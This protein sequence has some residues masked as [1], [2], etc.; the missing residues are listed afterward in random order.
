MTLGSPSNPGETCAR[1]LP[2]LEGVMGMFY[3]KAAVPD[4]Y[5]FAGVAQDNPL[6][7]RI[8][9]HVDLLRYVADH[10]HLTRHDL[11]GYMD[12]TERYG[13]GDRASDD[14]FLAAYR[15]EKSAAR[16]RP[17][18]AKVHL[19]SLKDCMRI[20]GETETPVALRCCC[21]G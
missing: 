9:H 1:Q 6:A 19:D 4:I 14:K 13:M 5:T 2:A 12:M 21:G 16:L 3:R 10:S 17:A 15:P 11:A 8:Q 20:L 18:L 7:A